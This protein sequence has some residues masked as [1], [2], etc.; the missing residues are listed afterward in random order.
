MPAA[1]RRPYLSAAPVYDRIADALC[2]SQKRNEAA[3][4]AA[5]LSIPT[6][7]ASNRHARGK[8]GTALPKERGPDLTPKAPQ[9]R[10]RG[11]FVDFNRCLLV[12]AAAGHTG[13]FSLL[14]AS[15]RPAA[16]LQLLK[17][18]TVAEPHGAA[19]N[20]RARG[21][22][23]GGIGRRAAHAPGWSPSRPARGA[24]P[25]PERG[26]PPPAGLPAVRPW[27][28]RDAGVA[29]PRGI[30]PWLSPARRASARSRRYPFSHGAHL[31]ARFKGTLRPQRHRAAA[32]WYGL[33]C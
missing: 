2:V 6:C 24:S 18:A 3:D 12:S 10:G 23:W 20:G 8:V 13:I 16:P 7:N 17:T 31:A 21:G 19:F 26:S 33:C 1:I 9:P 22:C 14:R 15:G 4:W 11:H 25:S 30:L 32:F 27:P 5:S 29:F 28:P